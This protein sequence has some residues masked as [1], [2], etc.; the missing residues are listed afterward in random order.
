MLVYSL[1]FAA[2]MAMC[3]FFV[4]LLLW[5]STRVLFA[6]AAYH[7]ALS[8]GNPDAT[9]WGLLIGL[10]GMIPGIVYLCIRNSVKPKVRCRNCGLLYDAWYQFCPVCGERSNSPVS[11][12]GPY[13]EVC[14]Q[15]AKRE[16]T[17]AIVSLGI[18]AFLPILW[19]VL[20]LLRF[21]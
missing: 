8:K 13:E 17:A 20:V 21:H 5:I 3:G 1:P 14:W 16:L 15:K 12:Y 4:M 7:D 11:T 9:M 6:L 19:G 18:G 2:G 10:L